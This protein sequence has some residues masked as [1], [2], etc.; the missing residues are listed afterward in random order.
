M[1]TKVGVISPLFWRDEKKCQLRK[2]PVCGEDRR[3]P[4]IVGRVC[5]GAIGVDASSRSSYA[6]DFASCLIIASSKKRSI[7][8]VY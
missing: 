2:I 1:R 3:P 8:A 6:S 7:E 5:R 4:G